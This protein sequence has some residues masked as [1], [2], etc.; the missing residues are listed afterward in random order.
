MARRRP[1]DSRLS[2]SCE[3]GNVRRQSSRGVRAFHSP[4]AKIL[5]TGAPRPPQ[6]HTVEARRGVDLREGHRAPDAIVLLR[7]ATGS[8]RAPA[9][10]PR[11]SDCPSTPWQERRR[12]WRAVSRAHLPRSVRP[13]HRTRFLHRRIPRRCRPATRGRQGRTVN[14]VQTAIGGRAT[15]VRRP[16]PSIPR[17]PFAP[18][19]SQAPVP[20]PCCLR[21]HVAVRRSRA[22]LGRHGIRIPAPS[23]GE[24]ERRSS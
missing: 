7:A 1:R 16:S 22:G 23:G 12:T 24:S 19:S 6:R 18:R 15:A 21:T 13:I 5:R 4:A 11:V 10:W 8:A 14:F 20:R 3:F 17:R 9:V 2:A